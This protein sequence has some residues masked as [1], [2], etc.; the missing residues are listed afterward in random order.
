MRLKAS[1]DDFFFSS[2]K[3]QR[4]LHHRRRSDS[5]G[6]SRQTAGGRQT[7]PA[8]PRSAERSCGAPAAALLPLLFQHS[9]GTT[10]TFLPSSYSPA[11]PVQLK[12]AAP[13]VPPIRLDGGERVEMINP[14]EERESLAGSPH[15]HPSHHQKLILNEE[16]PN[17]Q[18]INTLNY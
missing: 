12:A 17:K 18:Q 1:Q 11:H 13:N 8:P 5:A 10:T 14:G 6:L 9:Y 4:L 3:I 7:S 16:Q 2:V 15:L